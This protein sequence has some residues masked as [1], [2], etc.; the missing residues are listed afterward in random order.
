MR[1]RKWHPVH[2]PKEL[3]VH[4]ARAASGPASRSASEGQVVLELA[5][6][7]SSITFSRKGWVGTG[8]RRGHCRQ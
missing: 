5:H 7:P 1:I 8:G 6:Y 4:G 2:V 3:S